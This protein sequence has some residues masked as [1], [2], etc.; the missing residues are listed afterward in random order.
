[1]H[2]HFDGLPQEPRAACLDE[3]LAS[4]DA[5]R[6]VFAEL[7]ELN[8]ALAD[9]REA[10]VLPE[11][12]HRLPGRTGR[13]RQVLRIAAAVAFAIGAG[14]VARTILT[15]PARRV[16]ETTP[17]AIHVAPTVQLVAGS[18]DRFLPVVAKTDRPDVHIVWLHQRVQTQKRDESDTSGTGIQAQDELGSALA[19]VSGNEAPCT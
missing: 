13:R 10:T 7:R 2:D 14:L 11:T 5:C 8:D 9:L 6:T 18:A 19:K 12:T 16:V 15:G 4:C 1:M 3:H 17:P